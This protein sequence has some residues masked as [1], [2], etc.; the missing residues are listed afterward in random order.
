MTEPAHREEEV[1]TA[2]ERYIALR[3]RLDRGDAAWTDVAECF[4]DDA[5]FVDPA[6]GRVEGRMGIRDLM[7]TAMPGVEFTFPVDFHAIAGDWVVV[8]WRQVLPGTRPDGRRWEQPGVSTMRYAGGGK[9][10]YEEDLLNLAHVMEDIV[11]SGWQ[12]GPGFTPP[13]DHPDRNFD[14]NPA[15]G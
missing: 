6:W 10:D 2:V 1:R 14:P 12:P 7:A 3:E 13:P 5:V 15:K 8:K 11:A 9:F 4:T